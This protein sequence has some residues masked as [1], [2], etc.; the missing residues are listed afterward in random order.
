MLVV[1]DEKSLQEAIRIKLEK[2]NFNVFTAK[3]VD[4]AKSFVDKKNISAVWLDHY[5]MGKENGLDFIVDIKNNKKYKN[6]PIFVVSN[7][8]TPDKI[9]TYLKLGANKYYTKSNYRLEYII[10]DI[11][12]CL[13]EK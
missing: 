7:T 12:K 9:H 11:N 10:D 5:L 8:V 13:R 1:E 4:E 2:N 3:S 6:I